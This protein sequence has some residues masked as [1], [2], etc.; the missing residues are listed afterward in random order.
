MNHSI[1]L[2]AEVPCDP[3][4]VQDIQDSIAIALQAEGLTLPCEINVL[5]TDDQGIQQINA[6]MRQKDAVTDVLSFPMFD[7][8]AGTPPNDPNLLD[9]DTDLLPLG[10]MVLSLD[11]AKAQALEYG[12]STER[13]TL[14][15]VLHSVLHLLGY[16]HL[17]EGTQKKQ[18]RQRETEIL[19]L[20]PLEK[21]EKEL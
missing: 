4:L 5:L 14:Y 20:L 13:E 21:G 11:R 18:M 16:D 2:E 3:Q 19:S 1:L 17:D 10:D 7:L 9:F 12:H 8:E 6:E 15:L